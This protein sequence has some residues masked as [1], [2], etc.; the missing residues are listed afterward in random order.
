MNNN[1]NNSPKC[2]NPARI[3][4]LMTRTELCA[5]EDPE[6]EFAEVINALD[7][8][9]TFLENRSIHH[10]FQQLKNK[11][12]KRLCL[13]RGLGEEAEKEAND[14]LFNVVANQQPDLDQIEELEN[15]ENSAE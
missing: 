1:N 6:K 11:A 14:Q 12:F 4:E 8:L 5:L 2:P 10:K 15:G 7:W 3:R 9:A 13:E